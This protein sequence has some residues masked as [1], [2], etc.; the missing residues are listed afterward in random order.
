MG[1]RGVITVSSGLEEIV[2]VTD[3]WTI[4]EWVIYSCTSLKM[5]I[6]LGRNSGPHERPHGRTHGRM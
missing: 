6:P 5:V 3:D 2:Q 1:F 4:V